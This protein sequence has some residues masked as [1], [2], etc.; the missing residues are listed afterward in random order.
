MSSIYGFSITEH[1]GGSHT[2][3]FNIPDNFQITKISIL[4]AVARATFISSDNQYSTALRR[5]CFSVIIQRIMS[6]NTINREIIIRVNEYVEE[7]ITT[8]EALPQNVDTM[9][10]EKTTSCKMLSE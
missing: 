2:V 1:M 6:L 9:I 10:V 5:H 8:N 7:I 4:K 3:N